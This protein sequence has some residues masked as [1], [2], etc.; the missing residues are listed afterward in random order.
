MLFLRFLVAAFPLLFFGRSF[1][2]PAE[3]CNNQRDDDADG[4]VDCFDPDCDCNDDCLGFYYSGCEPECTFVPNCDT[5]VLQNFWVSQANVGNYP[6]V[7]V[8]DL[9]GDG[10]PEI[11]THRVHRDSLFIIDGQNG[12]TKHA[13]QLP[14]PMAG[15]MAPALGDIDQDGLGEIILVGEDRHI[16]CFEHD[17][18]LKYMTTDTVGYGDGY[19]W[20][21]VNLADVDHNGEVEIIIGN[22]VYSALDGSL[23]ASGGK[24]L[25]DG[26]H[27]ARDG[28]TIPYYFPSPV[29]V[30]ALPDDHCSDCSGLEIL[31]GNQILSINLTNGTVN[32]EVQPDTLYSDGY[33]S[34]ADFDLDG[35][36]DAIIQGKVDTQN[37]VYVWDI[38]TSSVL[39]EFALF[40][41]VRGGASRPNVAD[42]DGDGLPEIS[43]VS[44][45]NFYALDHDFSILWTRPIF[46][47]SAVTVSTVFDFCGNGAAEVIYRDQD[48]LYIF[49]GPTGDVKFQVAC[50]SATHVEMPIIADIDGDGETEIL[51][52]C[53][54]SAVNGNVI[55]FKSANRPW[56]KSRP[57]WNQHAFF[58]TNINDDLTIPIQQQN[59]NI[60][61]DSIIMNTFLNQYSNPVFP[62]PDLAITELH[63]SCQDPLANVT[64]KV[65]NTGDVRVSSEA[66]FSYYDGD[67]TSSIISPS[68]T[69]SS[70]GSDL[71]AGACTLV[72]FVTDLPT[73]EFIYVVVNDDQSLTTP[74]NIENSF[75]VTNLEECNY[76]NNI[77]GTFVQ[78]PNTV[79]VVDTIICANDSVVINNIG[80]R[81]DA[82]TTFIFT[83]SS[84]CD[85]IVRYRVSAFPAPLTATE[86][87]ICPDDSVSIFGRFV[88]TPGTYQQINSGSN[89]CDSISEITLTLNLPTITEFTPSPACVDLENGS[90]LL[91]NITPGFNYAILPGNFQ[92]TPLFDNL[93]AGDYTLTTQDRMGC[94]F[95]SFFIIPE[96]EEIQVDVSEDQTISLGDEIQLRSFAFGNDL[97]TLFYQWSPEVHLSCVDCPNPVA[98]PFSDTAY[99]LTITD[100][101]GCKVSASVLVVVKQDKAVYIPNAFSP[102]ADGI[103]DYFMINTDQSVVRIQSLRIFNRWG[104][105]VSEQF[106]FPPNDFNFGWDGNF[107]SKA[108]NPGVYVYVAVVEFVDQTTQ[109]FSGDITLFR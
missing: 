105:V 71:I 26:H 87:I 41:N 35:D 45:D 80:L 94:L 16:Y 102:N 9:D 76:F 48:S 28:G 12:A 89:S 27:P 99:E 81:A 6:V 69:P 14:T 38:Q 52:T 108:V 37:T 40:T 60:V 84:N 93:S 29:V 88:N 59:P 107:K 44:R 8:G 79:S 3:N 24:L 62:L 104:A 103:N 22:Q 91:E 55:A 100:L 13:T 19:R 17:A 33:T 86:I 49:N 67:P 95:E 43:F 5:I 73:S 31:A 82:D 65:C 36:L 47:P 90:L 106:Q 83:N 92:D 1:L 32:V 63:V 64:F 20:S 30:D 46:D 21:I 53:G 23:L 56:S 68:N 97:D 11:V 39:F 7:V 85:S 101:R 25:S 58:N 4:L 74:F 34:I 18:T 57:V 109:Q 54:S 66:L 96:A 75:P 72:S 15:G 10:L 78:N 77:L 51:I 61:R 98:A 2:P 42:L 70:I 50:E